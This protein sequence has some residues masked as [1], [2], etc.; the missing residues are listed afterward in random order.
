MAV[1]KHLDRDAGLPSA[2]ASLAAARAA[3]RAELAAHP[4]PGNWRRDVAWLVAATSL[5]ALVAAA[6][7]IASSGW[8]GGPW[9][10]ATFPLVIV[11]QLAAAVT[12]IHPRMRGLRRAVPVLLVGAMASLVLLR[13]SGAPSPLPPWVCTVSHL[14]LGAGPVAVG[15]VLLRRAA[16]TWSRAIAAGVAAGGVGAALGELACGQSAEHV[17]LFHLPAWAL[18]VLVTCL[19]SRRLQ[20]LSHAP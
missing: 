17:L 20:T 10:A 12:A 18:A 14:A 15:L 4:T 1:K 3:A 6:V 9:R 16:I 5:L 19:V 7:S 13:G 2:P 11:V 8:S